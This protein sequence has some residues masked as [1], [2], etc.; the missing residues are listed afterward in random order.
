M[1]LPSINFLP[2]YAGLT[3]DVATMAVVTDAYGID[4]TYGSESQISCGRASKV[5]LYNPLASEHFIICSN[6]YLCTL[7]PF[8]RWQVDADVNRLIQSWRSSHVNELLDASPLI[9][10]FASIKKVEI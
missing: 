10:S 7:T 2:C 5:H 3:E 1:C 8:V 9:A 6:I 4:S